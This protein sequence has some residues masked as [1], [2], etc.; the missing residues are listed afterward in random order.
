MKNSQPLFIRV[1]FPWIA[2]GVPVTRFLF[3]ALV[4]LQVWP[5]LFA[6]N[7]QFAQMAAIHVA[8]LW[9]ISLLMSL[10][11]RSLGASWCAV[12]A[13]LFWAD[14]W[15]VV[16]LT[17]LALFGFSF[18]AGI[19]TFLIC[20][21]A[22]MTAGVLMRRAE[23]L[24]KQGPGTPA[25]VGMGPAIGI[26]LDH[27]IPS[28]VELADGRRLQFAGYLPGGHAI[29]DADSV[30]IAPGLIYRGSSDHGQ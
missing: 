28:W 5:I 20:A 27:P 21:R 23:D 24:A 17:V 4:H 11:W 10:V 15:V 2:P 8:V 26:V 12:A 18:E 6:A 19:W 29:A 3:A 22:G 1:L 9:T 25:L 7:A 14:A 13:L 30:V 16:A